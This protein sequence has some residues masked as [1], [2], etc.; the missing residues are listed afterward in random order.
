MAWTLGDIGIGIMAWI[1]IVGI[2]IMHKPAIICLKDYKLR[3][4]ENREDDW[5]FNPN[6]IG[7]KGNFS[8]WDDL[9]K[10]EREKDIIFQDGLVELNA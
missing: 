9:R 4:K 3:I 8:V 5:D 6:K 10:E 2:L 7:I 1:N